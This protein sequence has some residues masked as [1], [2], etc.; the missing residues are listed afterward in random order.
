MSTS[1]HDLL[2][3]L[4]THLS[5]TG[6]SPERQ[7]DAAQA[8]GPLGRTLH[9]LADDG[10]SDEV[11]G[12]RERFVREL[13]ATCPPDTT[14]TF[15]ADQRLSML[16][17]AIADTVQILRPEQ[18]IASRWATA[19]ELAATARRL[20]DTAAENVEVDSPS[21][22]AQLRR[23]CVLVERTG[24]IEPPTAEQARLLDRAIPTPLSQPPGTVAERITEAITGLIHHTRPGMNLSIAEV[25][26]V[27]LAAETL[28]AAAASLHDRDQLESDGL[29]SAAH[30]WG[31]V[32]IE[33]RPF[34]DGSRRHHEDRPTVVAWAIRLHDA[35]L[36]TTSTRAA[37]APE[38]PA[39]EAARDVDDAVFACI[40]QL[41]T[42]GQ[43]LCGL[44]QH[45][46]ARDQVLAYA[47]QLPRR[48]DRLDQ[49]LAGRR[50]AGLVRA[51]AADLAPVLRS[52]R[53][54]MLTVGLPRMP[55]AK[56]TDEFPAKPGSA[57]R[58]EM[59]R[60]RLSG[61]GSLE[62]KEPQQPSPAGHRLAADGVRPQRGHHR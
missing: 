58:P 24:A 37:T 11:G 16:S 32:G 40:Q 46:P 26:A 35:L 54:A 18:R 22:Y 5:S 2:D 12:Y 53:N 1:L 15:L 48:E 39:I 21:P 49:Q 45:W 30:A 59:S 8:L 10:V 44:I 3:A 17:G 4:T 56:G 38:D 13:A 52:V 50:A 62:Q 9:R 14:R 60:F 6:P 20:A 33:L 36:Q 28:C 25:L 55:N 29:K 42:L 34:N 31:Q 61:W 47:Q 7:A 57:H 51:D 43:H 23:A 27:C 41:P 19:L